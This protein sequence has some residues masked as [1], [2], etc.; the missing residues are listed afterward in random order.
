M[1]VQSIWTT[2]E[3]RNPARDGF[4]RLARQVPFREMYRVA[5]LHHVAQKVRSM[6]EA[7]QNARDLLTARLCAPL[8]IH[9]R[10]FTRRIGILNLVDL[11]GLVGHWEQ[12]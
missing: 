1:R 9:L 11:E 3:I 7:F 5:E 2:I 6:A 8:V 10:D 4:L 12:L